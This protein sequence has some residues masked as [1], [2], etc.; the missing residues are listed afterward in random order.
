MAIGGV[1]LILLAKGRARRFAILIGLAGVLAFYM[2]AQSG[3]IWDRLFSVA[4][5][6]EERDGAAQERLLSWSAGMRMVADYPYGS[7]G[8]AAFVSPRGLAYIAHIRQDGYRSVHN[9][10]INIMAGW[11]VQGLGLLISAFLLASWMTLVAVWKKQQS[12]IQVFLGA[13]IL[14]ALAG[15]S[16]CTM[17]GDYLD[18]EWFI[19]LAVFGLAFT[20]FEEDHEFGEDH[21]DSEEPSL[22]G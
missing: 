3:N 19:W 6:E 17:F 10:Y 9:G 13:S 11:G 21:E 4:A 20:Q 8:H 14:A 5:S 7:G 18:G 15:Q 22:Q 12:E 2:Q 1:F 16:V